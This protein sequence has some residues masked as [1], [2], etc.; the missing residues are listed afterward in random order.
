MAK[1]NPSLETIERQKNKPTNGEIQLLKFLINNLDNSY[2]VFF[3]PLLNGDCPDI[4]I[5]R[6]GYGVIIFEVKDWQLTN[7]YTNKKGNW[8]LKRDGTKIQTP[9]KQVLKYKEIV[10]KNH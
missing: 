1:L 4:I 8:F 10:Y 5:M 9:L 3:Q 6:K 2:D 7:Y